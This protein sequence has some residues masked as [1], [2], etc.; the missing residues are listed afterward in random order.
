M[1]LRLGLGSLP[2][3]PALFAGRLSTVA[4]HVFLRATDSRSEPPPL[5]GHGPHMFVL[6]GSGRHCL[7]TLWSSSGT[8]ARGGRG[9]LSMTCS[10]SKAGT[11]VWAAGSRI[12]IVRKANPHRIHRR[13]ATGAVSAI[14]WQ[15]LACTLGIVLWLIV[16][17]LKPGSTITMRGSCPSQ[18][19]PCLDVLSC[20]MWRCE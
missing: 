17:A 15:K 5:H 7:H 12:R 19:F 14:K 1:A 9:D 11:R 10:S 13:Y 2:P 16:N 18:L 8:T 20:I 6:V 4:L 3:G